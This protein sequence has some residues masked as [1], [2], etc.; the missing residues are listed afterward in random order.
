VTFVYATKKFEQPASTERLK[1]QYSTESTPKK[2]SVVEKK[3]VVKLEAKKCLHRST[4]SLPS[5]YTT[6][7]KI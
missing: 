6:K 4:A 5:R 1:N 2:N 3:K 7:K